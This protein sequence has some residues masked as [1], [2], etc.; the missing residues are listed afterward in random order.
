MLTLIQGE[1]RTVRLTISGYS[2]IGVTAMEVKFSS[3]VSKTI[4]GGG[5]TIVSSS[6]TGGV[7]DV[8]L[9]NADTLLLPVGHGFGLEIISDIS[10]DRK[11][12]Q[13]DGV[14]NVKAQRY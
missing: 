14:Y 9:G 11:I 2:L 4:A 1:D 7:I 3:Q 8:V 10:A 6:A 12:L 5:V 13:P